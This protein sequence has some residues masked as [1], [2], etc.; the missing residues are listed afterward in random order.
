MIKVENGNATI[1]GSVLDL[2]AETCVVVMDIY[3]HI[4][5]FHRDMVKKDFMRGIESAFEKV[6]GKKKDGQEK[7]EEPKE[8]RQKIEITKDEFLNTCA[9]AMETAIREYP[10]LM[11]IADEMAELGAIMTSILFDEKEDK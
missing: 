2:M 4:P 3:K 9:K 6:D 5:S 8:D 10:P 7:K 1:K 11:I